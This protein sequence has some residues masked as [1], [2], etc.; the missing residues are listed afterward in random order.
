MSNLQSIIEESQ[1][2][3]GIDLK[4]SEAANAL[5]LA[6]LTNTFRF[7]RVVEFGDKATTAMGMV[8]IKSDDEA[9]SDFISKNGLDSH[10][11]EII[12]GARR[13]RET[14][15]ENCSEIKGVF[16]YGDTHPNTKINIHSFHEETNI[17]SNKEAKKT[18]Y[19]SIIIGGI[20]GGTPAAL[21]STYL[22]FYDIFS[23]HIP[24]LTQQG[25][26]W[27]VGGVL[28]GLVAKIYYDNA[29]KSKTK[30]MVREREYLGEE[31]I[32]LSEVSFTR[33]GKYTSRKK[34][35]YHGINADYITDLETGVDGHKGLAT[36]YEKNNGVPIVQ[37]GMSPPVLADAE[38][39]VGIGIKLGEEY[40][41]LVLLK[42]LTHS[43]ILINRKQ[44]GVVQYKDDFNASRDQ[45][46]LESSFLPK[47]S[48]EIYHT[49]PIVK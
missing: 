10:S 17:A 6:Y 23:S 24:N 19:K 36:W 11:G 2:L 45:V 39:G 43:K 21:L 30:K 49:L 27:G 28:G 4:N 33:D 14:I 35:N 46:N 44:G 3:I 16:L 15:L 38:W 9:V 40:V 29:S 7:Q 13:F 1:S 18:A 31:R 26:V 34:G 37:L 25:I 22:T 5:L 42:N 20:A 12:E 32:L 47:F 8:F 48:R 41:R